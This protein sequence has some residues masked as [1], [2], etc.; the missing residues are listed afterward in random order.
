MSE[1]NP[2]AGFIAHWK[3]VGPILQQIRRDELRRFDWDKDWALVDSLMDLDVDRPSKPRTTS[4]LVELQ[5]F[6]RRAFG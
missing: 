5:R 6:M 3:R 4:G 1:A 2:T